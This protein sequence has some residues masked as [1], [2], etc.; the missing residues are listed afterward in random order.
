M[1]RCRVLT[2]IC[3]TFRTRCWR[4]IVEKNPPQ[5]IDATQHRGLSLD[6]LWVGARSLIGCHPARTSDASVHVGGPVGRISKRA[7]RLVLI[8][9]VQS[10]VTCRLSVALGCLVLTG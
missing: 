6:T 9:V 10:C 3:A 4:L 1:T 8:I 7:T 5:L 2:L